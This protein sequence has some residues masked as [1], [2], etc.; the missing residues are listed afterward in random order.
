MLSLHSG[1]LDDMGLLIPPFPLPM[2]HEHD[3]NL[4]PDRRDLG[5]AVAVN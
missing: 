5:T 1:Y 3:H 4:D 2:G